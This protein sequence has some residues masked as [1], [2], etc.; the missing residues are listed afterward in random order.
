[1]LRGEVG[2]DAVAAD[3]GVQRVGRECLQLFDD[4][5]VGIVLIA[6]DAGMVVEIFS[7]REHGKV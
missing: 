5:V 7:K 3:V 1:M 6:R 4:A 2:H